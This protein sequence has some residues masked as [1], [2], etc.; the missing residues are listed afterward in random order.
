MNFLLE[1][2][3]TSRVEMQERKRTLKLPNLLSAWIAMKNMEEILKNFVSLW[4]F[5]FLR[6]LGVLK[7]AQEVLIVR[8]FQKSLGRLP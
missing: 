5:Y 7:T 4:I 3:Q 1:Q 2:F 8:L 6:S